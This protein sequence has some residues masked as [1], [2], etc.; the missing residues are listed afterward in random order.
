[1]ILLSLTKK[2]TKII[3]IVVILLVLKMHQ[4]IKISL[5]LCINK[6]LRINKS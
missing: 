2:I 5:R 3:L 1:M 6:I 4:N